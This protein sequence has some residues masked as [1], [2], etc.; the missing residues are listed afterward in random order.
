MTLTAII[1]SDGLDRDQRLIMVHAQSRI[2]AATRSRMKQCVGRQRTAH[3][4][5]QC[6]QLL[7]GW[8][9]DVRFLVADGPVFS[10][11]RIETGNRKARSADAKTLSQIARNNPAGP[12]DEVG[13]QQLA[14]LRS[15]GHGSS[16]EQPPVSCTTA[17]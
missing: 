12:D 10:G 2:I 16:P 13:G 7:D 17:S 3:G 6:T 15:A 1:E 5:P 14:G 9:Y 11:M 8:P 4:D